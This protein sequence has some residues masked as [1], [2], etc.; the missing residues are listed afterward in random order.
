MPTPFSNH[1]S[2]YSSLLHS[3]KSESNLLYAY[4][5]A[6]H[7]FAAVLSEP[8]LEALKSSHGVLTAYPDNKVTPDTTHSYKF[9]SLNTATGIWPASNYGKDVIIGVVDSGIWPESPS[10]NDDGMT[11]IPGRW[12]GSCLQGGQDFNSSLCNKKLIGARYFNEGIRADNPGVIMTTN[13]VRDGTGHGTHVASTVA[14]N[15]VEGVSFFGYA[16]GTKGGSIICSPPPPPPKKKN[17]YI[18]IIAP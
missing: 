8:Q 4:D 1:H 13:S 5:N 3:V 17:I 16:P 7:G 15:Y 14:G 6:F 9:L 18:Y 11:E 10:F 2:W 12:K